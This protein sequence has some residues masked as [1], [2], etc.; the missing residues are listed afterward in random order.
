MKVEDNLSDEKHCFNELLKFRYSKG[1]RCEKCGCN[2]YWIKAD[3][4]IIICK[5]CRAEYSPLA[6]TMFSR[7]HISLKRWFNLLFMITCSPERVITANTVFRELSLGS[8]RTAWEALNKL[9]YAISV[10][11]P[12]E[13]LEGTIEFDDIVISGIESD[14]SKISILGSLELNGEKRLNLQMIKNPDEM[15]IKNYLRQRFKK[16]VT[17]ITD[18]DKLYIQN[19]L[20]LNRI[21]FQST[22]HYYGFNFM[23][24][25]IILQDLKYGLKKGHHGVSEKYLQRNLDEYMFVFNHNADRKNALELLKNYLVNTRISD[26][27]RAENKKRTLL[28]IIRGEQDY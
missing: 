5:N 1:F 10:N 13:R 9:R 17:V 19:W 8:Y 24:L 6:G 23:N 27:K 21:S 28:S 18:P 4:R 15:N 11:E 22:N 14:Y 26:Y 20:K 2:K 3:R 25:H 7:S 12:N 16:D